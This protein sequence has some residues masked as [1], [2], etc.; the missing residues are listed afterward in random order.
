MFFLPVMFFFYFFLNLF[1]G[2]ILVLVLVP[3]CSQQIHEEIISASEHTSSH[4]ILESIPTYLT[5]MNRFKKTHSKIIVL[6]KNT[7]IAGSTSFQ[8][9]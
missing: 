4:M 3:H 7:Q 9:A 8:L 1:I 2:L 6:K 5:P